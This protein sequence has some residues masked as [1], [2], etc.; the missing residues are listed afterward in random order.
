M[1]IAQNQVD[2]E[3]RVKIIYIYKY[4]YYSYNG[5]NK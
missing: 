3:K 4:K 2:Q 5:R 1:E